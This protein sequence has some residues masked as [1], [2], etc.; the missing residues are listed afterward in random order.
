MPKGEI[1]MIINESDKDD[2]HQAI[3]LLMKVYKNVVASSMEEEREKNFL[4]NLRRENARKDSVAIFSEQEINSMPRNYK[5]IF[6]TGKV[7]AHIRRRENGLYEVR[8]MIERKAISGSGMTLDRA[9]ENFIKALR[10]AREEQRTQKV[11]RISTFNDFAELW[12]ETV[13]RPMVKPITFNRYQAVYRAHIKKYF[14]GMKIANIT[15]MQIQPLFNKLYAE[16]KSRTALNVKIILQQVFAAAVAERLAKYNPMDAVK[17][18]KHH[19]KRSSA[20]TYEEEA[21]F[22][23]ALEGKPEK[24]TFAVMLFGGM[25]RGELKNVRIAGDFLIIKNGKRRITEQDSER[26]VPITPMLRPF[27][28]GVTEEQFIT[29]VSYKEDWLDRHFKKLCP[30]HHLHELRHTFITRCQECGVP[31]EVVSVW[32]GHSAD[33]TMT[34]LVYTHFS[35]SFLFRGGQKVDYYISLGF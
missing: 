10:N 15:A 8:C 9:K 29:A 25:R 13:K 27:L 7:K 24:I 16:G 20:L 18:L 35:D 14:K 23:R 33:S 2:I 6:K 22:L 28:E 11:V 26:K 30:A 34:S 19:N 31:R 3:M 17:T 12:L 4:S 1:Q 21:A 32:A 5:N